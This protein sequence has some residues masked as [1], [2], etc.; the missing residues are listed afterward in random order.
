MQFFS[1]FQLAKSRTCNF[2]ATRKR[3]MRD[4]FFSRKKNKANG[5]NSSNSQSMSNH[6]V[7]RCFPGTSR[8]F[9]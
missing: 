9:F 1:F 8:K 5:K 7:F 6:I 3:D 2:E 4:S